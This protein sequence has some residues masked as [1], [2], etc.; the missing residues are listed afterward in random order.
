M[1]KYFKCEDSPILVD[2]L[3]ILGVTSML[4]ASKMEEVFPFR[5][6]TIY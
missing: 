4:I 2:K 5:L 6:K 1:D 3:H